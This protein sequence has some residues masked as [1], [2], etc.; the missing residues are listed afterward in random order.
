MKLRNNIITTVAFVMLLSLLVLLLMS[1]AGGMYAENSRKRELEKAVKQIAGEMYNSCGVPRFAELFN[2]LDFISE[3]KLMQGDNLVAG[4]ESRK[5]QKVGV[6]YTTVVLEEPDIRLLFTIRGNN[7]LQQSHITFLLTGVLFT[8]FLATVL[9]MLLSLL[10][11]RPVEIVIEASREAGMGIKPGRNPM[12]GRKDEA[13]VMVSEFYKLLNELFEYRGRLEEKVREA[14]LEIKRTHEQLM[15][16]QRLSATGKLAAGLAHEINNPLGGMMNAVH[17]LKKKN[18]DE[19]DGEYFDLLEDC[20]Q[21]IEHLVKE[22]LSFVRKSEEFTSVNISESVNFVRRMVSH[23]LKEKQI[24]FREEIEEGICISGDSGQIQQ[25]L[26]NLILN[27]IDS[28]EESGVITV[29]AIRSDDTAV[30][31][32]IDNGHGISPEHRDQIFDLFFT[33]KESGKGTGLGLGIVHTIAENHHASIE[34]L[35]PEDGLTEMRLTFP[36]DEKDN[37]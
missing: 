3:W 34:V 10:V 33:T 11:I 24:D 30:L 5:N 29:R 1:I 37:E 22:L 19:K 36:S 32:V 18:H 2:R 9:Y 20:I 6:M 28:V 14:S 23:S 31:S 21:R 13:G 26:L 35:S 27:S 17:K 25:L 12:P 7:I 8:L 4:S 16:S 15:L